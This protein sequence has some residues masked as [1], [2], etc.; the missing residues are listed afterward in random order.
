[1]SQQSPEAGAA[2]TRPV[3]AAAGRRFVLMGWA[4]SGGIIYPFIVAFIVL[5]AWKG[6][7]FYSTTNL[8][9]ILDQQA[10]TLIIA[11][12]GTM[13]LVAGGI[14]L[15]VGA[16]YALGQVVAT[17]LILLPMN[18]VPAIL[19]GIGVGL[20]AGAINGIIATYFRINSLIATLAMSFV[21]SG[22]ASLITGG[23]LI[24]AN[25]APGFQDFASTQFLSVTTAAWTMIFVVIVLG[26]VLWRTVAGRYMYAA[27]SNAEAARL[28]GVRVQQVKL[29]TFVISGGAAALGG[30]IDA[31]RVLSAQASNGGTALTFTVLAGIV[32]GGTSILGGEGAIWRTVAGT[33][34]IAVIG[35]GFVLAA[36]NPLYEQI[37]L[38]VILLIAVGADA[39]SRLRVSG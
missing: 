5:S 27:G 37:T 22:I 33:L 20:A 11:A 12:A 1:M 7:V 18:P 34:F 39:W 19:I 23:N 6:S 14:D 24:P 26:V 36:L 16:T 2:V 3:P 28:A 29:L 8:L 10:S 38:G 32:V 30:I 4:R 15:S 25:A 21:I 13:V 35:N 9:A 17:K 31:S